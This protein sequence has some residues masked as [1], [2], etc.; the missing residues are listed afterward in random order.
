MIPRSKVQEVEDHLGG[1]ESQKF[2]IEVTGKAF[3]VLVSG[4]YSHKVKSIIRELWSNARDSHVEAGKADVPFEC[5]LPT[6]LSPVFRVRDFGTGISHEDV[7]HLYTTIFK[8]SK[9]DSNSSVGMLGLGSKSPFSYTDSF[10]VVAYDGNQRRTY[11]AFLEKDGVPSIRHIS[12]DQ[13]TEPQGLEV[14][15]AVRMQDYREFAEAARIIAYGFDVHPICIGA[16]LQS[17]TDFLK[18]GSIRIVE[19]IDKYTYSTPVKIKQGCVIYPVEA[20]ELSKLVKKGKIIII[21]VPIGSVDVTASREALSLDDETKEVVRKVIFNT[22]GRLQK[23]ISDQLDNT[24]NR[25]QRTLKAIDLAKW[26][27]QITVND[28]YFYLYPDHIKNGNLRKINKH[29]HNLQAQEFGV[30]KYQSRKDW[31]VV[32]RFD[33]HAVTNMRIVLDDENKIPRKVSRLRDYSHGHAYT[34]VIRADWCDL[35]KQKVRLKRL[36]GLKDNQ[37]IDINDLPDNA[38]MY[39][40][41]RA[42]KEGLKSGE[43]WALRSHGKISVPAFCGNSQYYSDRDIPS[44]WHQIFNELGLENP[45]GYCKNLKYY[46]EKESIKMNLPESDRVDVILAEKLKTHKFNFEGYGIWHHLRNKTNDTAFKLIWK[47]YFPDVPM[48]TSFDNKTQL[49]QYYAQMT[50][51]LDNICAKMEKK[52]KSI[53]RDLPLL[54]TG[55]T[56][57]QAIME[58]IKLKE[59]KP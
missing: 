24:K 53:E 56:S 45:W 40:A 10:S 5:D 8:S 51:Q 54:F 16:Q 23:Y 52:I 31:E 36:L 46:T 38:P 21:E 43:I 25:Y 22:T 34:Y 19:N 30:W 11:I 18:L 50:G 37:F 59:A 17:Y 35:E 42:K 2:T 28:Q 12:T 4:L 55:S 27:N 20:P 44:W 3:Q 39:T 47:Q 33:I 49:I 58:Y 7:L 9:T 15:F 29:N 32:N 57:E 14:S 41:P 6:N 13:S 1:G 26:S 48:I